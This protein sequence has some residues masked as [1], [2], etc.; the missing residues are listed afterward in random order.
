MIDEIK[1]KLIY[2]RKIRCIWEYSN[3]DKK[4]FQVEEKYTKL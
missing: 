3:P 1:I 2:N 4:L